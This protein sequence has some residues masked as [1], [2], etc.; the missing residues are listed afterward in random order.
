MLLYMGNPDLVQS[1]KLDP[2]YELNPIVFGI[3]MPERVNLFDM[4][5]NG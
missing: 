3:K 2:D 4:F 5:Y 1:L